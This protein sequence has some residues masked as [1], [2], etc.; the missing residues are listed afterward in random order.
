MAPRSLRYCFSLRLIQSAV[1]GSSEAVGSSSSKS[2]G[3]L[4]SALASP[5]RVF[6]PAD[7]LPVGR[8]S[9]GLICKSSAM[10][11]DVV[12]RIG[13]AVKAGSRPVRFCSTVSRAGSVDVRALE[14]LA[15]GHL[16]AVL[17]HIGTEHLDLARSGHRRGR[18]AWRWSWSCAV[19]AEQR[20]RQ[21]AQL[22]ADIIHRG[23]G[24]VDLG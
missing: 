16:A 10:L 19:A 24:A 5:T 11:G 22:V 9:R 13:D 21:W 8:S 6:W 17:A 2:S 14:N 12:G 18:A 7:S 20:H 3:A 1:S 15:D 4:S 23:D